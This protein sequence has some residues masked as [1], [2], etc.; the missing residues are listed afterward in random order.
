MTAR[1]NTIGAI[2]VASFR[3]R[4]SMTA[5]GAANFPGGRKR[6]AA[7][8]AAGGF[9]SYRDIPVDLLHEVLALNFETG[10]MS[11]RQRGAHLFV[12]HKPSP[13]DASTRWNGRY[14]GGPAL[15]TISDRGYRRGTLFGFDVK[16]HVCAWA[17]AS[18]GWSSKQ[19]DHINGDRSDNRPESLREATNAENSQNRARASNNSSGFVGVIFDKKRGLWRAQIKFEGKLRFLGE[20]GDTASAADAYRLAKAKIHTFCPEVSR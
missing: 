16:A 11:W 14:A 5:L 7:D 10:R 20:F 1:T 19:I 13:G 12:G 6:Q 4:A 15:D 18:G 8:R 17:L 2:P 9:F 3:S